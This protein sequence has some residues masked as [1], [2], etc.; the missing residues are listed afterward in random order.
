LLGDLTHTVWW[1]SLLVVLFSLG[2]SKERPADVGPEDAVTAFFGA[3]TDR[4]CSA[5]RRWLSGD[6]KTRFEQEPCE[7]ALE[8]LARK[9]FDRVLSSSVDG[10]DPELVLVRA[11]FADERAPAVIGVRKTPKGHRIV[12]F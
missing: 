6:A 10:R 11:G 4:D 5:A 2:C 3:V 7:E 9:R 8:A 1:A 12:S